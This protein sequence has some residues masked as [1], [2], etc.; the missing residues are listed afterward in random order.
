M[1][2]PD[3]AD[4]AQCDVHRARPVHAVRQGV[5]ADPIHGFRDELGRVPFVAGEPVCLA[6]AREMLAATELPRHLDIA[7]P[8]ELV[9]FD[10]GPIR[11][12]PLTTGFEVGVPW[13]PR[14][15]LPRTGSQQIEFV[16]QPRLGC[17]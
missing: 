13:Q 11:C 16:A 10:V 17:A 2:S 6:Q 8:I 9:V 15:E 3:P 12:R 4:G 14:A 5:G 7:R 1:E